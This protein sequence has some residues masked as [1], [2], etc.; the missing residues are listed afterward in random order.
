MRLRTT[1]RA[2][3]GPKRSQVWLPMPPH[4]ARAARSAAVAAPSARKVTRVVE[5]PRKPPAAPAGPA[6]TA[7]SPLVLQYDLEQEG[8][9]LF[10]G[11][12]G[13][14][15]ASRPGNGGCRVWNVSSGTPSTPPPRPSRPLRAPPPPPSRDPGARA[16]RAARP[17]VGKAPSRRGTAAAV[18]RARAPPVPV[19]RAPPFPPRPR[20]SRRAVTALGARDSCSTG[21]L[22]SPAAR[23]GSS[24][25]RSGRILACRQS[26][27]GPRLVR[28]A[29]SQGRA[30]R[31]LA[32]GARSPLLRDD[33][34]GD[35]GPSRGG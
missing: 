34:G 27:V 24:G 29:S 26:G 7:A 1:D 18:P 4:S 11:V 15:D 5:A 6:P 31:S 32:G 16:Q 10:V 14:P 2:G 33:G 13:P 21:G 12:D 22:D 3:K 25:R 19:H 8:A 17:G 28:R 9:R 20:D 35:G 23:G 30:A